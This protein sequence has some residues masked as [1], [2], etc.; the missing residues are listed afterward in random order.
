MTYTIKR[1]AHF[2][3]FKNGESDS[4]DY[5]S[6]QVALAFHADATCNPRIARSYVRDYGDSPEGTRA[7]FSEV[8]I[9]WHAP[10]E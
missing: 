8:V 3:D 6:A 4:R 2:R 5:E 7:E 10:K 9:D 1:F